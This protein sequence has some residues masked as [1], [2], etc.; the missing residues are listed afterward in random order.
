MELKDFID[1]VISKKN[2]TITDEVFLLIQ[3]DHE[4]MQQYLRFVQKQGLDTVNQQIGKR[5][6]ERYKLDNN[7]ERNNEPIS[8]L[9]SSF[10]CFN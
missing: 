9:I 6:K 2:K 7:I 1:E 4:F 5:V 3:N 10:Q 8:T